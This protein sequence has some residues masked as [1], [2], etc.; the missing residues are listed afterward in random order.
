[1]RNCHSASV[2]EI[3]ID[4]VLVGAYDLADGCV[5]EAMQRRAPVFILSIDVC[6][7]MQESSRAFVVFAS[8]QRGMQGC[9]ITL[10]R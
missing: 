9:T 8:S 6:A 4:G 1:M 5:E 10:L 2:L 3:F 7:V